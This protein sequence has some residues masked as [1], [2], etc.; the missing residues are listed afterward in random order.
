MAPPSQSV[1]PLD[2]GL[3]GLAVLSEGS[4]SASSAMRYRVKSSWIGIG[5]SLHRV[6]SLSNTATRSPGATDSGVPSAVTRRTKSMMARRAG[7][8][9]HEAS[10][11]SPTMLSPPFHQVASEVKQRGRRHRQ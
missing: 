8:S 10:K 1:V 9:R 3:V 11:F 5:F 7:V 6:P 2:G 4:A